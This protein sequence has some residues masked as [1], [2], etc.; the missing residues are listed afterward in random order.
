MH[1]RYVAGPLPRI[2]P[3]AA[4]LRVEGRTSGKAVDVP[5]VTVRYR[6]D[7][8]VASM[9]GGRANWVLNVRA[10]DGHAVFTHGR[11]RRVRLVEVPVEQRPP[12]LRR[13][14]LV[15]VG[16]RPHLEVSWR[17]P[18]SAFEAVADRYPVFRVDPM[19]PGRSS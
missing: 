13:Y 14:L 7:W 4:V 18:L 10:A 9:L 17:D 16:A 1:R 11:R 19:S 6:G 15:A 12:I 5:L 8:Y 2:V 3:F